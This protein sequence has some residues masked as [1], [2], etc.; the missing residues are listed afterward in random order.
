[1]KSKYLMGLMCAFCV[2][3]LGKTALDAVTGVDI[4]ELRYDRDF[5]RAVERI[6]DSQV[7]DMIDSRVPDMIDDRVP[8]MIDDRVPD[9]I[10]SKLR[11]CNIYVDGDY[12]S[13]NCW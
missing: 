11:S 8:Y 13:L 3:V 10:D 2:G 12:G 6:V 7:R 5:Q 9:M 1:M 4:R